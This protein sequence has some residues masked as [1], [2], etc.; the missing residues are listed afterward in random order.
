MTQPV[1]EQL[2]LPSEYGKPSRLVEWSAVEAK[3]EA[4][5]VY[6]LASTRPDG[7]PHVVPRDGV[8]LDQALWYGGSDETIHNRNI[9]LNPEVVFHI[10]EGEEAVIVEGRAGREYPRGSDAMRLADASYA[11]YPRYGRTDPEAYAE[12]GPWV[13]RPRRVIAWTE[14]FTDATRFLF[15]QR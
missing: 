2:K 15:R 1:V 7:R 4:A 11:K 3:L 14:L 8:W 6:W 12:F 13:I 10:G 5:L 9:A